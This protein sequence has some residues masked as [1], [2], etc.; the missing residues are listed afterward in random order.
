MANDQ[1]ASWLEKAIR[2]RLGVTQENL[3]AQLGVTFSTVNRWENEHR[4]PLP[5]AMRSIKEL[6][7][8]VG[9]QTDIRSEASN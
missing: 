2:Q 8:K 6:A 7:S 4:S 5:L 9:L 1:D 3:A